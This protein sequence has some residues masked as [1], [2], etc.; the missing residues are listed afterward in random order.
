MALLGR[1]RLTRAALASVI[2]RQA[3]ELRT[4][5]SEMNKCSKC[6]LLSKDGTYLAAGGMRVDTGRMGSDGVADVK[7]VAVI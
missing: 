7:L 5:L 6:S 3:V 1:G 2:R 4:D